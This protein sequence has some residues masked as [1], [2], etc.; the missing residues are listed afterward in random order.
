MQFCSLCG[1]QFLLKCIKDGSGPGFLISRC[2]NYWF[3]PVDE[4]DRGHACECLNQL[5]NVS[6]ET[7]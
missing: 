3:K 1:Q 7:L 6:T 2:G 4:S 5:D